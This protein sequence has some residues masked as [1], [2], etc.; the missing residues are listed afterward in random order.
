MGCEEGMNFGCFIGIPLDTVHHPSYERVWTRVKRA[1][2]DLVPTK[3]CAPHSALIYLGEQHQDDIDRVGGIVG[4]H[5]GL[6]LGSRLK[7]GGLDVLGPVPGRT[8]AG[9]VCLGV[10]APQSVN[11]FTESVIQAM[12]ELNLA[13]RESKPHF[14]LA[15][16]DADVNPEKF[17]R[18]RPRIE[19]I[20]NAVTW[21]SEVKQVCVYG[22]PARTRF[23]FPQKIVTIPVGAI[24]V[25]P[26]Q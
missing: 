19:R 17:E 26:S 16:I 8:W 7:I 23:K 6:L 9:V 21:E 14:S 25:D 18:R 12:A 11:D 10:E 5:A 24:E 13:E 3:S 22:K 2:R 4:K 1:D 15:F 20:L